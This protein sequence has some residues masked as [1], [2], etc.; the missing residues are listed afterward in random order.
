MKREV[1]EKRTEEGDERTQPGK[2]VK[3]ILFLCMKLAQCASYACS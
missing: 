2:G 1:N 3:Q